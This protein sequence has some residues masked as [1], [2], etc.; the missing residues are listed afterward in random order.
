M[1]RRRVLVAFAG[2]A[3]LPGC[4]G[5][6]GRCSGAEYDVGMSDSAFDPEALTVAVGD[7]VR[8][9][10]TSGRAHTVTAYGS[11]LPDGATFFASG[12][13]ETTPAAREGW[14]DGEGGIHSCDAYE[15]T[16]ETAGEYT[17]VCIPHERAGMTGRIVVE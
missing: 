9:V 14:S 6:G 10:N 7:T 11:K 4:L 3:G 5:L 15:H 12:D 13:F 2:A 8:W 16:F 17:Y 1:K